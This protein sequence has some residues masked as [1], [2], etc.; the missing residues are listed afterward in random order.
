MSTPHS[1]FSVLRAKAM[2]VILI[3]G[4]ALVAVALLTYLLVTY[5]DPHFKKLADRLI[6]I[7]GKPRLIIDEVLPN[8]DFEALNRCCESLAGLASAPD[9][10]VA[11]GGGSVMDVAKL[12]AVLWNS[13]QKLTEVVGPGKVAQKAPLWRRSPQPPAPGPK[14]A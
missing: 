12:V 8:P 5:G 7:A 3:E 9:C 11:L 13:D 4:A 2:V 6:G 1:H 10:I 14:A